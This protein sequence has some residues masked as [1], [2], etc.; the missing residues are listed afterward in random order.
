MPLAK[1]PWCS[2]TL[3]GT[4]MGVAEPGGLAVCVA[5][6]Q[7]CVFTEQLGVRRATRADLE[8]DPVLFA[9]VRSFQ[10]QRKIAI[11]LRN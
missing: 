7:A 1:C 4:I 10:R 9:M 8:A 11:A 6:G 5:C 2:K 3:D